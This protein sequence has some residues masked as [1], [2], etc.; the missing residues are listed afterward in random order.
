MPT[1]ADEYLTAQQI[2]NF[3]SREAK[4][5]RGVKDSDDEHGG[6]QEE[7]NIAGICATVANGLLICHPVTFEELNICQLAKE[8]RLSSLT[9]R[10]LK[11]ICSYFDIGIADMNKNRKA[12]YIKKNKEIQSLCTC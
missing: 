7:T 12:Q 2:S 1:S 3:F 4:R 5:R 8:E 9:L 11:A 6:V 10:R